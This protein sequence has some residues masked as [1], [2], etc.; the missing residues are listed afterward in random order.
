MG[1]MFV[2]IIAQSLAINKYITVED[3]Q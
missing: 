2:F 3:K 1:L